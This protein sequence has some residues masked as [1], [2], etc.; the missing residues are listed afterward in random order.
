M[1][2]WLVLVGPVADV[3]PELV[4]FVGAGVVVVGG[5]WLVGLVVVALVE[6][7]SVEVVVAAGVVVWA[8]GPDVSMIH[9]L[10]MISAAALFVTLTVNWPLF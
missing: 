7:D 3:G 1:F 4:R 8:P 2:A 10:K 9:Q 6:V 5:V